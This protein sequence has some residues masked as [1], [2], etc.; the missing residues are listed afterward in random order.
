MLTYEHTQAQVRDRIHCTRTPRVRHHGGARACA[1]SQHGHECMYNVVCMQDQA[2]QASKACSPMNTRRR[3]YVIAYTLH[4][5]PA[6]AT[7]EEPEHVRCH[8]MGM[9]VCT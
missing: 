4:V 1:M 8:S 6:Y 5:R 3:R 9:S 2:P 7:M